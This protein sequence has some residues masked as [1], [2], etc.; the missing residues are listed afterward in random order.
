MTFRKGLPVPAVNEPPLGHS[1]AAADA[2]SATGTEAG[3]LDHPSSIKAGPPASD[4]QVSPVVS[5]DSGS[6]SAGLDGAGALPAAGA[7]AGSSTRDGCPAPD[8]I[9]YSATLLERAAW[10]Y[11]GA[12]RDIAGRVD[13]PRALVQLAD[14]CEHRLVLIAM[15]SPQGIARIDDAMRYARSEGYRDSMFKSR[16]AGL[17]PTC[18]GDLVVAPTDKG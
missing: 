10:E 1:S 12:R 17:L 11:V 9:E 5:S 18:D 7:G 4:S 2:V 8:R 16:P 3:G 15:Q 14:T 6:R 13:P